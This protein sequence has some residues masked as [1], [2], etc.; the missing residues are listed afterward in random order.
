MEPREY[1]KSPNVTVQ[2]H[3]EALRAYYHG[4]LSADESALKFGL[5][6]KYFKKLR[7]EFIQMLR[8]ETG[9]A[10]PFFLIKKTGPKGRITDN[11]TAERI[12][13]LRKQNHSVVD[14]KVILDAEGKKISLD[15][16]DRILALW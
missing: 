15:T 7:S 8:R 4:G 5:S 14:I 6:P 13:A 10:D 9:E 11:Q 16:I 1:F 12:I 3:Y 2:R